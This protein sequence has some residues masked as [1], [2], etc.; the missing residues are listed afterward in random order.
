M[1]LRALEINLIKYWLV[2]LILALVCISPSFGEELTASDW[3]KKGDLLSNSGKYNESFEAYNK[4]IALNS[5]AVT[6]SHKG[7]VLFN[8][9]KYNNETL[10]CYNKAIDIDPQYAPAWINKGAVLF[11]QGRYYEAIEALDEA[12]RLEPNHSAAWDNKGSVLLKQGMYDEAIEA[13]DEA[14]RLNPDYTSAWNNKGNA[15]IMQ[16]KYDE[17]IEALDEAIRLDPSYVDAHGN[18]GNALINK[19]KYNEAIQTYDKAIK[20]DP[21]YVI[22]WGNKGNALQN[23]GNY[24][25]AIEAY[26]EVIR[27]DPK[28][29]LA[30]NNKGNALYKQDR[31]DEAIEAYDE[32]IRLDSAIVPMVYRIDSNYVNFVSDTDEEDAPIKYALM[33]QTEFIKAMRLAEAKDSSIDYNRLKSD[34]S[35]CLLMQLGTDKCKFSTTQEWDAQS[36]LLKG[37]NYTAT[38][39]YIRVY[40]WIEFAETLAENNANLERYGW[41]D[42]EK[43]GI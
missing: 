43:Y 25:E 27:L 32:A 35:I 24:D 18:K 23:Q 36:A 33:L 11:K 19:K 2:L 21:N 4:S 28:D 13:Y 42:Y 3:L 16:G 17:A 40:P 10:D 30:W 14:I 1:S 41:P 39:G 6:W 8:L 38:H 5:S 9:T 34:P 15:L 20:L 37:R 12:I 7:N 29:A 31:Y 22:A 26:D